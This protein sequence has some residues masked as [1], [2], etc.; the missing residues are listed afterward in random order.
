MIERYGIGATRAAHVRQLAEQPT[1][2]DRCGRDGGRVM[3]ARGWRGIVEAFRLELGGRRS[4]K[5]PTSRPNP[6]SG[7][8]WSFSGSAVRVRV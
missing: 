1:K 2:A 4:A 8:P 5:R 3:A 6:R 7:A